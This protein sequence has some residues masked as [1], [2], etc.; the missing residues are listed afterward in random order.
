MRLRRRRGVS[1]PAA[2]TTVG[3]RRVDHHGLLDH[4]LF[5][6]VPLKSLGAAIDALPPNSQVSVTCS[7]AK[8]IAATQQVCEQLLSQGHSP[9][10][11]L[12]SRMVEGPSHAAAIA[13]WLRSCGLRKAFVI[14]GDAEHPVHYPDAVSFLVD[15]VAAGPD[16]TDVG[17]ASY[18]DGHALID[19]PRI[20]AALHAKQAILAE[21]GIA[22]WTTTQ[23]CFDTARI[24]GW[25]EQ[26][27]AEGLTLPVHVGLPGVVDRAKLMT[28]GARLGIGQSMRYLAK[29][30]ATVT[31]MLMPGGYDPTELVE[32]LAPQARRL[33][34]AGIHSFTFNCVAETAAWRSA[35]AAGHSE[36]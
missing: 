28:L 25:L 19:A 5:E 24:I 23:M 3:Q 32:A 17:V 7:P 18:P 10:P 12:S 9:V 31:R 14:G 30:R 1:G 29:N 16:L 34:I 2:Q 8:G 27:R 11:H 26:E 15:F 35:L 36:T 13:A 4:F 21:A 6:V 33:S 20:R 22:G